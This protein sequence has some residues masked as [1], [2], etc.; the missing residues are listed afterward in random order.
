MIFQTHYV[1]VQTLK[2]FMVFLI[3]NLLEMETYYRLIA[4]FYIMDFMEIMPTHLK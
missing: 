3:K 2:L 1:L 4:E